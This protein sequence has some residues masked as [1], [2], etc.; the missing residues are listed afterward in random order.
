MFSQP[1]RNR[2]A[3]SSRLRTPFALIVAFCMFAAALFPFSLYAQ[4]GGADPTFCYTVADNGGSLDPD[5]LIRINRAT[6]TSTVVI[7]PTG[8]NNIEAMSFL[9]GGTTLYAMNA[10]QLGTL[11]LVTG[12]FTPIGVPLG[13]GNG[14]FGIRLFNDIDGLA[15]R[16]GENLLYGIVPRSTASDLM[17]R[18][19]PATGA[20]V[21]FSPGVDYVVV[22]VTGSPNNFHD[23]DD[24]AFD[25]ITGLLYGISDSGGRGEL[26][27]I[28]PATGIAIYIADFTIYDEVEG[29]SFF[30]DGELYASSGIPN[31]P[32]SNRLYRVDKSNGVLTE[33]G[34]LIT[35]G[36]NDFEAIG[37]LVA[38]AFLAVEK[39]TNGV[40]AD[41][42][43]GP[44]II[45][46]APVTWTYAIRNT[47]TVPVDTIT[48][49]DDE[50]APGAIACPAFPQLNN[51]LN[52]NETITCSANGIATVGQYTNTATVTG[53]GRLPTGDTVELVS[54]DVSHYFG[55]Q[56]D[57]AIAK[58]DGGITTR[59]GNGVVYSLVYSNV[60]AIQASNVVITEVV[61]ANTTFNAASSTAGWACQPPDGTAGSTCTINIGTVHAS[62]LG[63]I[64]F[65]VNVIDSMPTGI[66]L[67]TNTATIGDDGLHG[68]ERTLDNNQA[69]DT[70][71]VTA[72]PEVEADKFADWKDTNTIGG[73]D[74]GELITYTIVVRN[75]GNQEI[76]NVPI[77]D[78]PDANSTLSV[79]TVNFISG[80]GVVTVGNN[81]GDT[82]I[83]ATIFSLPGGG[84]AR[85]RYQVTIYTPLPSGVDRIINR[86]LVSNTIHLSTTVPAVATPD[87]AIFKDD[88][89]ISANAGGVV[90]Y[91]VAYTNTGNRNASGVVIRETVPEHTVF[92]PAAS[93]P[94]FWNCQNNGVAGSACTLTIG[95]LGTKISGTAKFAVTITNT[96]PS[97]VEQIENL[98]R[99]ADDN[100]NGD[101]P[102]PQNNQSSDTTPV[103]ATPDLT[104]SKDDGGVSA[105]AGATVVYTLSYAN[106]GVQ[107]ATGVVI[108][109]VIPAH[110]I[111]NAA[112]ST[113]G[114]VC[115]PS[116]L[117]GSVCK[118][119]LGNVS[120]K[121]QGAV[122][123]AVQLNNTLSSGVTQIL[124][125]TQ[126]G[127]D[128]RNG[129]DPTPQN[130]RAQ[131]DTPVIAAPDLAV[132]KDDD[133]ITTQP[134]GLIIYHI[135][136]HNQGKQDAVGVTLSEVVP[137]NTIFNSANSTA[138]WT[139]APNGNAGSNCS[140]GVGAL[141]AGQNG[142]VNFAVTVVR[143]LPVGVTIINNVAQIA[144]DGSN[145]VDPT[146]ENNR[147]VDTTPVTAAPDL[148][149]DVSDDNVI[150]TPGA[151]VVYILKYSNVG[152]IN[153]NNVVISTTVP[154]FAKFNTTAR[155]PTIWSCAADSG[156]GTICTTNLGMVAGDGSGGTVQFPVIVDSK[157]PAGVDKI[158]DR[159]SIG[160]DGANGQ[161]PTPANN[162]D[163]EDTPLNA[164]P[165]LIVTKHADVVKVRPGDK[166]RYTLIYTNTGN[167]DDTGVALQETVPAWTT[168]DKA[169]STPGWN[170][171]L[172]TSS[173]KTICTFTVGSLA[174]G[175]QGAETVIFTVT[176][177]KTVDQQVDAIRN[178]VTIV[179]DGTNSPPP[180]NPPSSTIDVPIIRPTGLDETEEPAPDAARPPVSIFLPL[181]VR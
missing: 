169:N 180:S 49:A 135:D 19:D 55:V 122:R 159:A 160:D 9:P 87:L 149:I 144:D 176:V 179:D 143:P 83:A 84:E 152:T 8:T 69:V 81:P 168:F 107:N 33:L 45:V 25:P 90:V 138:G 52:P 85:I 15:Y 155:I 118:M 23:I 104:I 41:L 73:I 22:T 94:A 76:V 170:C 74:P 60:G 117:P 95:D 125:Q 20:I 112:S 141:A 165:N 132:T 42:M 161:D 127:D 142:S 44:Q 78:T 97:G 163:S 6:G 3:N 111:F 167:Q 119:Q 1:K 24:L 48:L 98:A 51:G 166:I 101:D 178:V 58:D 181:I 10:N 65:A 156:P 26:V 11:N 113:P 171:A 38:S 17:V 120:V 157:F 50:L 13:S 36:Y 130:N 59:P 71:P 57:L 16:S 29:L 129:V 96:L 103:N 121:Q 114:W 64:A 140:L 93:S 173:G 151:T 7:G 123:F 21:P 77:V 2:F 72:A 43:P 5:T 164:Q 174:A 102:T 68:A 18:I 109:D 28:D 126:I 70:T 67:L 61:P 175:Q 54:D 79:G 116:Q 139:C 75:V 177:D 124:N 32:N 100:R 40:D 46:G 39:T 4:T 34:S 153:A 91:T 12:A 131:D 82:T 137:A 150:A 62:Q 47:G 99:V 158:T 148:V 115:T 31:D 35:Q 14:A 136:Y 154:A 134:G 37:C 145:G 80:A 92:N 66:N 88:G 63:S 105:I 27:T 56:P 146:P 86:A 89:G 110:T 128:L 172:N 133:G 106:V 30:N 147:A 53:I 162:V 108:T